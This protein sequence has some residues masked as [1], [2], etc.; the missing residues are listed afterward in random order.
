[1]I[2]EVKHEVSNGWHEFTSPQVPG[3]YIVAEMDDLEAA[4]E[5]VPMVIAQLIEADFG[6]KVVVER[7]PSYS[8][9]LDGLPEAFKPSI[10]HYSVEKI[11]A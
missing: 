2:I 10:R 1:M 7:E 4:Y 11:A 5:D 8:E 3:L 9:Y 6:L